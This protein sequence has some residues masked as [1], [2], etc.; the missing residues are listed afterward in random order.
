[1][2]SQF[3][4]A[5]FK[6]V[7]ECLGGP[8]MSVALRGTC[9]RARKFVDPP[10]IHND[11]KAIFSY[12]LDRGMVYLCRI[13]EPPERNFCIECAEAQRASAKANLRTLLYIHN[14][15]SWWTCQC[16]LKPWIIKQDF[17]LLAQGRK[18]CPSFAEPSE[19]LYRCVVMDVPVAAVLKAV[20]FY[21]RLFDQESIKEI[22]KTIAFSN[23]KQIVEKAELL[24]SYGLF[25]YAV[26][27]GQVAKYNLKS[28]P[29]KEF[30]QPQWIHIA[31]LGNIYVLDY[32][33][34]RYIRPSKEIMLEMLG[35]AQKR[36]LKDM[37]D[38]LLSKL[39]F[40]Y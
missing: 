9:S 19:V 26:Y 6:S 36:G 11:D 18:L 23:A 3:S 33:M 29:I 15:H 2:V 22:T 37:I 28:K 38:S 21:D 30:S 24:A 39:E 8:Y 25:D 20:K 12:A 35:I 27:Y 5:L 1:M 17:E 4:E 16:Y 14:G 40:M 34:R 32:T 31:E 10:H 13:V 7:T